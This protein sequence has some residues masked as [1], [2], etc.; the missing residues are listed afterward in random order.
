MSAEKRPASNSFGSSQLVKRAKSDANLGSNAV[1][2]VNGAGQNG[3]LIQAVPRTSLLQAPVMEL[4]GHSGEVFAARFDPSG[5]HIASGSMDRSIL[6]WSS[7]G[8]CEN[9]GILT[10]HKQAVL[11]LHWS[12]DSRV[13]FSASAD[14][15]LASWDVE[16]GERIRRH[17][18]H[19]EVINCMDVS[20]RGEEMLVSGSDDG[21][22]GIWDPRTKDA[23]A[24]IGT[25]FPITAMTL[26]EAGNELF[27]G[28]IDNDIKVWDLRK[29]AVTYSLLGHTDTVTSLQ[30]SPDTQTLLSNAHDSTVRTWD[31][32]PFAPADRRIRTYDGAPSGQEKNLYKASWDSK[33]ERIAAGSGDQSV[34]I[35]EVRT[36][37]LLNKLPGHRGAVN[38]VRFSPLDEPICKCS[39]SLFFTSSSLL[40]LATLFSQWRH[41]RETCPK[42]ETMCPC[43]VKSSPPGAF[44]TTDYSTRG[45]V[46]RT[47]RPCPVSMWLV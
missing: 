23:V 39:F 16:T 7:S 35:W 11:D 24:F 25:D 46:K 6:L 27:T 10:G 40:S 12:R 47:N 38:D 2:V 17:P 21:Y 26:A 45:M 42:P 4:T 20:K 15:H 29:Q 9:Y 8:A 19:E 31:I 34:A 1:A 22:I 3:A 18:G 44:G 32:R 14:M 13:L 30:I 37:K 5:Q 36:G 33:G 43:S 41:G 28:G